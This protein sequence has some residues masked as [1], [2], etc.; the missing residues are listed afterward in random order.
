MAF[1]PAGF[2]IS[3]SD[4]DGRAVVVIRGELDLA[5]APD[6]EAA[7]QGRLD[8]GQD[9]VVDLRELDFM[10]STGLRVLVAAHA[11]VEGTEQHFLI[12]RPLPG[13]AI[14]RIL[15]VAGVEQ[16]LDLVDDA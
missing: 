13:A 2:S 14:E 16:V 6:L 15:A 4:R 9:V 10:D 3:I 7:I 1:D 5:T 11:R 12:V 8:D